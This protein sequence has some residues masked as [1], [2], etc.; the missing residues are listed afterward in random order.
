MIPD[1]DGVQT[2]YVDVYQTPYVDD[3]HTLDVQYVIHG[4]RVVRQQPPAA[5]RPL[6]GTSSQE[7]V[8]RED[9]EILMQL[10]STHAR[11]S[12][13]SLLASSS[14]HRDVLIRALS[15]IRVETTTTPEGLIH[16]V[17]AG[18][19][20]CIVFSDDGLQPESAN[21]TRPFY[22]SV[23]C[24]GYRVSSVILDNDSAL[25]VCPLAIAIAL[26]YASFDFG[27][28]TQIV[29]AYDNTQRE[30]MGTLEIELL[31]S[32]I[33]F[34]TLFQVLK[35]PTSFNLLL[36]RPWIHKVGVIPS[37]LYQKVKFICDGQVITVR[38]IGDMFIYTE[39]VLQ[40]SHSDD[41]LL[42][43]GFTFDEVQTLEMENFCRDF[44]A[45]SFD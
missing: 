16:V 1:V 33:T 24:S 4:G 28:F 39:L 10:Q 20:A 8:E 14:N 22:I 41:D 25:N 37:S 12:I 42:L 23:G 38:S 6:K 31:R 7:E 9:D 21:H 45:M 26:G 40:I 18:R 27:P 32:P 36:G 3:V 35:I 19:A 17:M 2:S 30:V 43:S 34:V 29:R 15:Q 13:W 11:I 5:A 44:V